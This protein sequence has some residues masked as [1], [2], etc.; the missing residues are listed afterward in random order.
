AKEELAVRAHRVIWYACATSQD[1][2][3]ARRPEQEWTGDLVLAESRNESGRKLIAGTPCNR[4]VR[5]RRGAPI[6]EQV[7]RSRVVIVDELQ[8]HGRGPR[9]RREIDSEEFSIFFH[10]TGDCVV[11]HDDLPGV[12]GCTGS[13]TD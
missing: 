2:G 8:C 1:A 10:R 13:L 12:G 7:I 3:S 6:G 9:R 4:D 11:S 5:V